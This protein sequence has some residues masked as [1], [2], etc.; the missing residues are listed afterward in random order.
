MTTVRVP[1]Y[2]PAD[3]VA[4]MD[5][6]LGAGQSRSEFIRRAVEREVYAQEYAAGSADAKQ[7]MTTAIARWRD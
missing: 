1:S 6:V 5:A 7:L 4:R 3:L 2:M